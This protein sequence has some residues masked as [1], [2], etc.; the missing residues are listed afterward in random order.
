[1]NEILTKYLKHIRPE[2]PNVIEYVVLGKEGD[3][4]SVD[5]TWYTDGWKYHNEIINFF[6]FKLVEWIMGE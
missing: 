6:E 1:M 5:V 3:T 2:L 4:W